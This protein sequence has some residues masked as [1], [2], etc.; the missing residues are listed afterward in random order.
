MQPI[1]LCSYSWLNPE[2]ISKVIKS[3][4]LILQMRKLWPR[5]FKWLVPNPNLIISVVQANIWG[6][7][8]YRSMENCV[9]TVI[10]WNIS[11]GHWMLSTWKKSSEYIDRI[12]K[13]VLITEDSV[14]LVLGLD[15]EPFPREG[16]AGEKGRWFSPTHGFEELWS[17]AT[18][19]ENLNYCR[20]RQFC[21][22]WKVVDNH[23][24]EK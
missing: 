11:F 12:T 7:R 10:S 20:G 17:H 18:K 6:R 3:N 21:P 24:E 5:E 16:A 22:K 1:Q 19:T 2:D 13:P 23:S 15:N 4:S 14:S 9:H 8:N